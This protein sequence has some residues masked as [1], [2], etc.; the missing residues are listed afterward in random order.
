MNRPSWRQPGQDQETLIVALARALVDILSQTFEATIT[1][2]WRMFADRLAL[3]VHFNL[4]RAA[5]R[6]LQPLLSAATRVVG[7]SWQSWT[8]I[9]AVG[10]LVRARRRLEPPKPSRA[11]VETQLPP[12]QPLLARHM[13]DGSGTWY[14]VPSDRHPR[15]PGPTWSGSSYGPGYNGHG[16][17]GS[18]T[19]VMQNATD[20]SSFSIG[21]SAPQRQP[22][23]LT[24]RL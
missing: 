20:G 3:V 19:T 24:S 9:A 14:F 18:A 6:I 5:N 4:S 10:L 11:L 8:L 2:S 16:Y 13:P 7:S 12:A 1:E 17:D 22:L 23:L 15:A 21:G